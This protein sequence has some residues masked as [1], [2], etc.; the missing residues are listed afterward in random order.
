MSDNLRKYSASGALFQKT[1]LK[2]DY[3]GQLEISDE[4]FEDLLLSTKRTKKIT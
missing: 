4:V 1:N 3:S 2:I